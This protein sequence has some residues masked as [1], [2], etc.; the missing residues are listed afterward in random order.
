MDY[1]RAPDRLVQDNARIDLGATACW[2]WWLLAVDGHP[3]G[4][5]GITLGD[6]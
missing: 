4:D 6:G 5:L 1:E 2:L 3:G